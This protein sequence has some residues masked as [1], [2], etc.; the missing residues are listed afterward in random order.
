MAQPDEFTFRDGDK[1]VPRHLAAFIARI[2]DLH[3]ITYAE[4][5]RRVDGMMMS[6]HLNNAMQSVISTHFGRR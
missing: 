3:T 2:P 6:D 5:V 4:A 1:V